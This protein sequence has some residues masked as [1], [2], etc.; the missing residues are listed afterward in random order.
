VRFVQLAGAVSTA[1]IVL[2]VAVPNAVVAIVGFGLL[3]GGLAGIVPVVFSAAGRAAPDRPGPALAAVATVGYLGLLA[4]PAA[5]GG[6]GEVTD[7]RTGLAFVV[8]LTLLMTAL[9]SR[10]PAGRQR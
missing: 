9:G 3:G 6:I 2:A 8:L 1:G 5:I 4:G 10:V 7:V